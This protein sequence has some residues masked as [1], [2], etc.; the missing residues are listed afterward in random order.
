MRILARL[1][2]SIMVIL[3]FQP[4]QATARTAT[5]AERNACIAR[6]QPRI[7]EIDARMRAGYAA[8]EGERL[9][10]RRRKLEDARSKCSEVK[11]SERVKAP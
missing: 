6:I 10:A 3:L 8:D 5:A 1:G 2:T 4:V 7:D 11:T 9:K